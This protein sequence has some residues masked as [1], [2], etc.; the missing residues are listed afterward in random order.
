MSL[1]DEVYPEMKILERMA[2]R[3][4]VS[5]QWALTRSTRFDGQWR[6]EPPVDDQA[7][8]KILRIVDSSLLRDS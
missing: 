3:L 8:R 4:N 2:G 6:L 1:K 5:L 7:Q